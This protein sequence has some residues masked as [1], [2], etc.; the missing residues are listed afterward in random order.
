MDQNTRQLLGAALQPISEDDA[1]L[2]QDPSTFIEKYNTGFLA[3]YQIYSVQNGY[4]PL[5]FF[6]V[7]FAP[8]RPAYILTAQPANFPALARADGVKI[9]SPGD[10]A[11]YAYVYLDVT[12][13]VNH[14]FY[15]VT[16]LGQVQFRTPLKEDEISIKIAFGRKYRTLIAPPAGTST[17]QGYQV[18]IYAVREQTLELHTLTVQVDGDISDQVTILEEQLPLPYGL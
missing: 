4:F 1:A 13:E 17:P 11:S 2:V 14:L 5:P 15:P 16:T 18:K 8:H 6:Y 7:G 9:Y 12:R 3:Y 10:A